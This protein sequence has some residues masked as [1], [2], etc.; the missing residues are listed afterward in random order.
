VFPG[1]FVTPT[2]LIMFTYSLLSGGFSCRVL[3]LQLAKAIDE[4]EELFRRLSPVSQRMCL[5]LASANDC[6]L[7]FTS[8]S[9]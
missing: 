9:H 7:S 1:S 8:D 5:L 2:C 4:A 3:T 6:K